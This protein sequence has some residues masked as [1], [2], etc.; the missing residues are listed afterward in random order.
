M[1]MWVGGNAAFYVGSADWLGHGHYAVR[2]AWDR[3]DVPEGVLP[4]GRELWLEWRPLAF[5]WDP[6][7]SNV[8]IDGHTACG[9][10]NSRNWTGRRRSLVRWTGGLSCGFW[11]CRK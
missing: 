3:R 7:A 1:L 9:R 5:W 8:T 6:A 11:R 2:L 4:Y 10:L